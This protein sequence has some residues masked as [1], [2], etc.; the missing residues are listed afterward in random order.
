MD[1]SH[2]DTLEEMQTPHRKFLGSQTH[3]H[4]TFEQ[5]NSLKMEKKQKQKKAAE[6]VL[7]TF[8]EITEWRYFAVP[9]RLCIIDPRSWNGTQ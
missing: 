9:L 7:R 8:I 1:R 2:T 5:N 3:N 4:V 6:E